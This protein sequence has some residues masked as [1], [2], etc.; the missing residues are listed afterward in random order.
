[1]VRPVSRS[2]AAAGLFLPVAFGLALEVGF[3]LA[4]AVAFP[5]AGPLLFGAGALSPLSSCKVYALS[6]VHY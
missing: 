2:I 4:F 5:L 1:M 6:T 3:N